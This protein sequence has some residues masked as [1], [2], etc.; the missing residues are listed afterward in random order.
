ME[1]WNHGTMRNTMGID[2]RQEDGI[3]KRGH[4]NDTS[5]IDA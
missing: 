3:V 2:G 4:A 5:V 1:Y